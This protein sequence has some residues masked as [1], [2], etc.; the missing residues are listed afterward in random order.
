M[1]IVVLANAILKEELSGNSGSPDEKIIWISNVDEFKDHLQ[2]EILID[3]LFKKEE[4][5]IN[6]L[7]QFL[8]GLIIINSVEYTLSEIHPSFV[9]INAW[10]GFLRS[11][12]IEASCTNNDQK[13][14]V[15]NVFELFNKKIEWLPDE[16]GFVTPR[17]ISMI[18]NEACFAL[19][20]GV[21]SREEIDI[22]MK[23]GTHYPFGP[24]EWAEKIGW[25]DIVSLLKKLA[26]V[27]S[28]YQPSSLLLKQPS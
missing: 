26:L 21:S 11:A 2:A 15:Q 12:L 8:P 1:Q 22:A 28:H 24:F 20:E 4:S 18:I 3:L 9:R 5:R 13:Q 19:E 10:N 16:P 27:N 25:G 17:I 23:L 7:Q 14:K 6:L